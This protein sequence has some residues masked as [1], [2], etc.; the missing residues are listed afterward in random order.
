MLA[1][2]E[3]ET[4]FMKFANTR[5]KEKESRTE[6]NSVFDEKV[7][8]LFQPDT[9]LA[10]QYFD[11]LRRKTELYPE[12][13]LMLAILEDGIRC[14]QDNI[15]AVHGKGTQLFTEA[16]EWIFAG[17]SDWPFSFENIC[18]AL[19][20]NPEYLRSGLL[21]WQAAKLRQKGPAQTREPGRMAS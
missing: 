11:S 10:A 14:F 2:T 12:K 6:T 20:L 3:Q 21:R 8:S 1:P 4:K 18:A 5:S 17:A 7:A 19:G 9:T 13:T 15:G 16:E